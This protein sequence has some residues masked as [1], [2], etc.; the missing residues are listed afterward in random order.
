MEKMVDC[1]VAIGI[2]EMLNLKE[3]ESDLNLRINFLPW[4]L[5]ALEPAHIGCMKLK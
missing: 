3:L 1:R 4:F 2:S 5:A